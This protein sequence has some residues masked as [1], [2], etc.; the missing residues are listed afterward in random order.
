MTTET[1]APFFVTGGTLSA[2][3]GSYIERESDQVLFDSLLEGQ[4]CYVLNS[5]QMGKSS[6]CVRTMRRLA[7]AGVKT[8]FIDLTR[9]GGR[10]VSPDQWYAGLLGELGRK[11][12][13]RA[14]L[15]AYWQENSEIG[16]MQRL[17]SALRNV[18]LEKLPEKIAIFI[19]EIDATRSLSFDKDEFFAGIRECYNRRVEDPEYQRLT[20]CLLGVALPNDL[21]SNP[22]S[23]PFNIGRRIFLKDFTLEEARGFAEG[24]YEADAAE[25]KL[26]RDA[27]SLVDRVHYWT[28]GQPYLTQSVCSAVAQSPDIRTAADVDDLIRRDLFE[29]KSRET[30]INLADVANRALNAGASDPNPERFKADMLSVYDKVRRG[31]AVPDDESNRVAALLKLSGLMRGDGNRLHVRNRIYAQVFD[32]TWV[33]ENMPG[34]ELRRQRRAFW[35]GAVRVAVVAALIIGLVGTLAVSNYHLAVVADRA[36]ERAEYEAYVSQVSLMRTAGDD[37]DLRLLGQLVEATKTS[38]FRGF[39]WNYW[40][41]KLHDATYEYPYPEGMGW[42]TLSADCRSA[43]MIDLDDRS[44]L[45]LSVPDLKPLFPKI[46]LARQ[47]Q[48]YS[49]PRGWLLSGTPD[50][51]TIT[52]IDPISGRELHHYRQPNFNIAREGFS[53]DGSTIGLVWSGNKGMGIHHFHRFDLVKADDLSPISHFDVPGNS[54]DDPLL[55]WRGKR[56][57]FYETPPVEGSQNGYAIASVRDA[58]TGKLLDQYIPPIREYGI[59]L[60]LSPDGKLLACSTPEGLLIVRDVDAKRTIYQRNLSGQALA[61]TFTRDNR[62][63]LLQNLDFSAD[64]WDWRKNQLLRSEGGALS[65]LLDLDGRFMIISGGGSRSYDLTKKADDDVFMT[66]AKPTRLTVTD[67]GTFLVR[68]AKSATY[69]DPATMKP[70]R[71]DVETGYEIENLSPDGKYLIRPNATGDSNLVEAKTNRTLFR[72]PGIKVRGIMAA[73]PDGSRFAIETVASPLKVLL[74]DSTGRQISE[75]N[76]QGL[77]PSPEIEWTPDGSQFVCS[78]D[79]GKLVFVDRSGQTLR[80]IVGPGSWPSVFAFDGDGKHLAVGYQEGKVMIFDL[81]GTRPPMECIG[82]LGGIRSLQFK[83]RG[84]RLLTASDD[85]SVRLW[86]ARTAREVLRISVAPG[87]TV[88]AALT[89]DETSL[90]IDYPT[91]EIKKISLRPKNEMPSQSVR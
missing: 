12:E 24:I 89:P 48:F 50:T 81:A 42:T 83:H 80:T 8:A 11:F 86:D 61:L 13:L 46:K 67:T 71:P 84:D 51:H 82:H 15:L 37:H 14:E 63:L 45:I 52:A 64:L 26:P 56:V 68:S 66:K 44:G 40:N 34:Q 62:L 90:A 65:A 29:P 91:G 38:R 49:T 5:R 59:R 9:I 33:R 43:A 75:T 20:F 41:A 18:V 19:D 16:P 76:L 36:R 57:A 39:E 72:L 35:L 1:R 32:R 87:R 31:K 23:T 28:H 70:T 58:R 2:S 7:E 55:D 4:F 30:N 3:A 79:D 73:S 88:T 60:G 22:I 21:I 25:A 85:G 78:C 77:Y 47:T 27:V 69:L 74:F 53:I 17:F 10:N 6:I 54:I